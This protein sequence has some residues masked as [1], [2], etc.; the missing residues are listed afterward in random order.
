MTTGYGSSN[1][2]SLPIGGK[3]ASFDNSS[4]SSAGIGLYGTLGQKGRMRLAIYFKFNASIITQNS[5]KN[6]F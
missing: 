3:I 5:I 1:L 4:I 2:K 6:D